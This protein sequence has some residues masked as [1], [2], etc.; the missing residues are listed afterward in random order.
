MSKT[1][2]RQCSL[3]NIAANKK[4]GA[5]PLLLSVMDKES[6]A[7]Q[8]MVKTSKVLTMSITIDY[9]A[10]LTSPWTYLGHE[11]FHRLA[12]KNK[13][14]VNFKPTDFGAVFA[15]TG[16]LP[17]GKRAPERQK[18]RF[19]ELDRWRFEL[20]IDLNPNPKHFPVPQTRAALMCLLAGQQG[21]DALK[22]A[23]AFM[24]G[25]WAEERDISDNDTLI[26]LANNQD[27]D[28]RGLLEKSDTPELMKRYKECADEAVDQGVFGAPSY[29]IEDE[30]FW[31]Q[32][33]LMFVE[34][35][36]K[37]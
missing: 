16:G 24:R 10:S 20:N 11:R 15:K 13:A 5:K 37:K 14:N 36:L 32:D 18:Y 4:Q 28:G 22:L 17:L 27:F 1:E 31:G 35:R 8:Y 2:R 19:Q 3:P 23:G 7:C 33:R 12:L 26:E 34:K 30:I 9:Y 29:V 25:V 6:Q 21:L